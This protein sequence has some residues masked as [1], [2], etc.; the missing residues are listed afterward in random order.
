MVYFAGPAEPPASVGIEPFE[1]DELTDAQDS[2]ALSE[3]G[4]ADTDL[5]PLRAMPSADEPALQ[6]WLARIVHQDEA[7][8]DSLYRACVGRV[9]GLALRIVRNPAIAEEV[10]E[11][12][13][14]QVWRQA[15]RFDAQ[16]GSALAWLLTIARSRA[17][18]ALRARRRVLANTVSADA[19]GEA[20][21]ALAEH[22][23]GGCDGGHGDPHDLLA[24][25]QT[26]QQLH[27]ALAQLDAVPRQLVALAFF[28]GLTHEEIASQID[29]PLGTVKSHLRRAM[30]ALR[31]CL[32]PQTSTA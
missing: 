30:L 21:D 6:A 25:V 31:K 24:A 27:Q 9:Y 1:I 2:D 20:M 23:D 10:T 11:D 32:G 18:D 12:C 8:L 26:N 28:K 7:A 22:S 29:L 17:L 13:F 19:L 4:H 3:D 5:A 14:W 15:P 16:R